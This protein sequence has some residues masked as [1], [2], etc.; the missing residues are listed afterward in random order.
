MKFSDGLA[1]CLMLLVFYCKF[2]CGCFVYVELVCICNIVYL[3]LHLLGIT[4]CAEVW[5]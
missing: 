1:I 4:C 3:E 2:V 5:L